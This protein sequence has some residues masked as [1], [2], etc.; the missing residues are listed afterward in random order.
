MDEGD[1]ST[2]TSSDYAKKA[3]AAEKLAELSLIDPKRAKRCRLFELLMRDT[4]GLTNE[5]RELKLRLQAME[6]QAHLRDALNDALREEVQRLKIATGQIPNINGNAFNRGVNPNISQSLSIDN[7]DNNNNIGDGGFDKGGGGSSRRDSG[8][9][10]SNG[11]VA[12]KPWIS[13]ACFQVLRPAALDLAG[14]DVH[15]AQ[16]I[17]LVEEDNGGVV[18]G[19]GGNVGV[20]D[21]GGLDEGDGVK[22]DGGDAEGRVVRAEDEEEDEPTPNCQTSDPPFIDYPVASHLSSS[23]LPSPHCRVI[24]KIRRQWLAS[25]ETGEVK[26]RAGLSRATCLDPRLPFERNAC[27]IPRPPNLVTT[28]DRV[29]LTCGQTRRD[30]QTSSK[31]NGAHRRSELCRAY[32]GAAREAADILRPTRSRRDLC[33]RRYVLQL[34]KVPPSD[35]LQVHSPSWVFCFAVA[36]GRGVVRLRRLLSCS[37]TRGLRAR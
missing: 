20:E 8:T 11:L 34:L 7:G 3:M 18:V 4:T 22:V 36:V 32:Y 5:N 26:A 29:A 33:R 12:I 9:T 17:S 35:P 13:G 1:S 28:C 19:E 2:A 31:Q 21:G 30:Q 37:E 25:T 27:A 15:E 23:L 6:Q 16:L 10:I 24:H 14:G